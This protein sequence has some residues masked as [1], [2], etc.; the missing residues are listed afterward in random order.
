MAAQCK[1][2]AAAPLVGHAVK[3]KA[4]SGNAA[5]PAQGGRDDDEEPPDRAER[6]GECPP[7]GDP[8]PAPA[9]QLVT[10]RAVTEDVVTGSV[11]CEA[12]AAGAVH[13]AGAEP[14]RAASSSVLSVHTDGTA[15]CGQQA[16]SCDDLPG[17]GEPTVSPAPQ[18]GDVGLQHVVRAC[19][20]CRTT[21]TPLW[22]NGPCGSKTLCN[23][24]G[25]RF[26]L[27][28]LPAHI[29][30]GDG[31]IMLTSQPTSVHVATPA[32]TGKRRSTDVTAASKEATVTVDEPIATAKR[33]RPFAAAAVA[34]ATAAVVNGGGE[35]RHSGSSAGGPA[36]IGAAGRSSASRRP[37]NET[38]QLAV[39]PWGIH[40]QHSHNPMLAA[41]HPALGGAS[42]VPLL[43]ASAPAAQFDAYAASWGVASASQ[44]LGGSPHPALVLGPEAFSGAA[45]LMLLRTPTGSG[46][47]TTPA[48]YRQ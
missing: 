17:G 22:R 44:P 35:G 32:S 40:Q 4:R 42:A 45:L 14:T 20:H 10:G 7:A 47:Q 38:A 25:V 28:K 27:G 12:Q 11:S 8:P 34:A 23:A 19:S 31:P 9:P 21:K 2:G 16:V 5:G 6:R 15:A 26:K 18:D 13:G 1:A 33:K 48:G 39:M 29:A 36:V 41:F 43:F 46:Q 24:C 3:R 37:Y 30:A